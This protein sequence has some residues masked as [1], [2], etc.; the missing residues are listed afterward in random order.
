MV[1]LTA[2]SPLGRYV[3]HDRE[4]TKRLIQRAERGGCKALFVTVDAPQLGRREKD[5][6]NKFSSAGTDVQ[7]PDDDEGKV[8]RSQVTM[9][10]CLT[11]QAGELSS[12]PG[13][14]SFTNLGPCL[15][16]ERPEPSLSLLIPVSAGRTSSGLRV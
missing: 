1:L 3:N 8:D 13:V 9:C 16:R 15:L 10:K 14:C 4:V 12:L 6:R 7:K 11:R 5:M 2:Q